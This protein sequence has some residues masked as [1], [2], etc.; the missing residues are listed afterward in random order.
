MSDFSR[1]IQRIIPLVVG[2]IAQ[3]K[4]SR[5][6]ER[7]LSQSTEQAIIIAAAV[8]IAL[9]VVLFVTDYVNDKLATV[10]T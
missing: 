3:P 8:A 10:G 5:R 4:G 7:G 2:T 6:D 1:W 9:T